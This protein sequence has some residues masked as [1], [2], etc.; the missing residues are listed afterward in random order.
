MGRFYWLII[1]F[2]AFVIPIIFV[3]GGGFLTGLFKTQRSAL[4]EDQPS[5]R[6]FVL[7]NIIARVDWGLRV[8]KVKANKAKKLINQS[9]PGGNKNE[10][11]KD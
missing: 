11:R 5:P 9:N 7:R 4:T 2:L 3:V 1:Y 10:K 8:E 6:H